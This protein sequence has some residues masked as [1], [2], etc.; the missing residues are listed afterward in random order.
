MFDECSSCALTRSI[1]QDG[2]NRIHW[3]MVSID[4]M[5][6]KIGLPAGDSQL[7]RWPRH[8]NG[9]TTSIVVPCPGAL[10]H[11]NFPFS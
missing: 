4:T 10:S 3:T 8:R 1:T 7:T 11:S 2:W 6:D 9:I 5:V